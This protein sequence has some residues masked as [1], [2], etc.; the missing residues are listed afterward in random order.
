MSTPG[1][2]AESLRK[3]GRTEL[4]LG[5]AV[6]L[7]AVISHLMGGLGTTWMIAWLVPGIVLVLAGAAFSLAAGPLSTKIVGSADHD[8]D[9]KHV[10]DQRR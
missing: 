1:K 6:C 9:G 3:I 10:D 5:V 7:G 8:A 2:A 4:V